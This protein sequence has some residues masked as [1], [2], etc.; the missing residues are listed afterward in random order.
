MQRVFFGISCGHN[1]VAAESA[2][3][4]LRLFAPAAGRGGSSPWNLPKT[5]GVSARGEAINNPEDAAI[6]QQAKMAALRQPGRSAGDLSNPPSTGR[7]PIHKSKTQ[8]F[9]HDF[10][11]SVSF[12]VCLCQH[13]Q[14]SH[15]RAEPLPGNLNHSWH[16]ISLPLLCLGWHTSQ[17]LI[18]FV[19]LSLGGN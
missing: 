5:E 11:S 14:C 15:L 1:H 18:Q 8:Y 9:L 12:P 3:L 16:A 4:L 19:P 17:S 7:T 6:A 13:T 10:S 2:R